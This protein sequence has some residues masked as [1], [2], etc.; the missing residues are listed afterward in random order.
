MSGFRALESLADDLPQ[1][2]FS[3][4]GQG[5]IRWMLA[6]TFVLAGV[7]KLRRPVLAA[8]AMVDFAVA[9][10]VRLWTGSALG[11]AEVMIAV[12]LVVPPLHV[13]GAL[14]AT[15]LLW[16]FT[17]LI[18]RALVRGASFSCACFGPLDSPISRTTLLRTS[19]LAGGAT[20]VAAAHLSG[21]ISSQPRSVVLQAIAG[22]AVV[23]IASLT[24]RF[25]VL[26]GGWPQPVRLER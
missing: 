21:G 11:A 20:L 14:S 22:I 17:L 19:I 13:F 2:A 25:R 4:D 12:A 5:A 6:A 1:L 18:A 3:P 24:G 26:L 23:S 10:R 16:F 15:A 9:S 8:L 7:A